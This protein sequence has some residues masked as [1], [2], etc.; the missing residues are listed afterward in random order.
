MKLETGAAE[1]GVLLLMDHE[2]PITKD[3]RFYPKMRLTL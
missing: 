2:M 1:S 3:G